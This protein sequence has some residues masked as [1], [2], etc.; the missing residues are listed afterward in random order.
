MAAFEEIHAL[1]VIHGD[2]RSEN[3]IISQEGKV[4]IIDFEFAEILGD[5]NGDA[6][7]KVAEE[8]IA[9]KDMLKDI[10]RSRVALL[11]TSESL[12]E[13]DVALSRWTQEGDISGVTVH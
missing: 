13:E 7:S 6:S 11:S 1:G 3:I 5:G 12:K 4:W 10:K 8:M 9:L 2:V